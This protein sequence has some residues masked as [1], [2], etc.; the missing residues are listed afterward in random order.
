MKY[1]PSGIFRAGYDVPVSR[2]PGLM[3]GSISFLPSM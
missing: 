1:S 2:R 3:Y